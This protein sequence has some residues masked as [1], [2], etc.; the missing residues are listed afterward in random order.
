MFTAL[1]TLTFAAEGVTL[2][3]L[4]AGMTMDLASRER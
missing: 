2:H 3:V 4:T 1:L